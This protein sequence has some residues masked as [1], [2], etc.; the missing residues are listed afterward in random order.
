VYVLIVRGLDG[1]VGPQVMEVR[2]WRWS[3]G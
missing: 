1:G 3:R 2:G